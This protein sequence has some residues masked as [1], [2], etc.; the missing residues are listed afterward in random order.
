MEIRQFCKKVCSGD[1]NISLNMY[2]NKERFQKLTNRTKHF[3]EYTLVYS[4][5]HNSSS[6]QE[7]V[8]QDIKVE[9]NSA[10]F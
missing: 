5:I 7:Y 2:H 1:R 4:Q 8:H 6:N 9:V 10:L 3:H